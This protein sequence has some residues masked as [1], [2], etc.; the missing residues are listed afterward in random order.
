MKSLC[1][2]NIIRYEHSFCDE[3]NLYIVMEFAEKGDLG[4]V[5]SR[6]HTVDQIS[7]IQGRRRSFIGLVMAHGRTVTFRA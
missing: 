3:A 7:E 4:E 6:F 2:P 1:H 5:R